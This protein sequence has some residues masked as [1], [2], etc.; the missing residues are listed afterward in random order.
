LPRHFDAP[1]PQR[2]GA[3]RAAAT[4][5]ATMLLGACAHA[6]A[7]PSADVVAV[8]ELA[9]RYALDYDVPAVLREASPICLTV[10]GRAP[11]PE[12][13][14][15]LSRASVQVSSGGASCAGPRAVLLEVSGVAVSG[16]KAVA[17]AG[18][19]LGPS[20]LLDF[21]SVHGEWRVRQPLGQPSAGPVLTL[22]PR[23][24]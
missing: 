13:L 6:P 8:T 23:P 15:R 17:R 21:R 18:V 11:A 19:R 1:A 24:Q 16:D 2:L 7:T 5:G 22:P 12:V 10:D 4:A 9:A 14:A 20:S 3:L